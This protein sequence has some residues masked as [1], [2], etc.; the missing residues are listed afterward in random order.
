MASTDTQHPRKD[1][2]A[3]KGFKVIILLL[4]VVLTVCIAFVLIV[5]NNISDTAFYIVSPV[6]YQTFQR[7]WNTNL[8][9]IPLSVDATGFGDSIALDVKWQA[10][11]WSTIQLR[12][13]DKPCSNAIRLFSSAN[14]NIICSNYFGSITDNVGQGTLS[15]RL[16]DW[17]SR[18]LLP[19]A[20]ADVKFVGIGDV[21]L[22]AGQ[23]N[24]V[25][26]ATNFQSYKS[27]RYTAT[28]FSRGGKWMEL[29]DKVLTDQRPI[30]YN[31]PLTGSPWPILASLI[32]EYTDAPVALIP[33][34]MGG[35]PISQ[36]F[37]KGSLY[38][39]VIQQVNA[40]GTTPAL[41]LWMQGETEALAQMST[42]D[43]QNALNDLV[44]RVDTDLHLRMM[45][46]NLGQLIRPGI[47]DDDVERI[48][49]AIEKIW[50]T[51]P[52]VYRGPVF[53]DIPLKAN[54]HFTTDEEVNLFA[55]R[56]F[57]SLQAAGLPHG[58]QEP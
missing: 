4:A 9:T 2:P 23:S 28:M 46:A 50:T 17:W 29:D 57:E 55:Q 1:N 44:Q 13:S 54:P 5:L 7:D 8:G 48:R 10:D 30:V 56:W 22:L 11:N 20:E 12:R 15:F 53:A 3:Y 19:S 16:S 32:T 47:T 39:F 21:F 14:P 35:Q 52:L 49:Q 27:N 24:I 25:G 51:N 36:W 6:D 38:N 58:T 42:A 43:Y 37:A 31:A 41:I 40:S 33:T 18:L 45:I 26:T 34:G